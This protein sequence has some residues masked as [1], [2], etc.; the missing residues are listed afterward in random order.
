MYII[1]KLELMQQSSNIE[2]I[3]YTLSG[4]L[5]SNLDCIDKKNLKE[6]SIETQISQASILRFCQKFGYKGVTHFI[7]DLYLETGELKNKLQFFEYYDIQI[8]D[9]MISGFLK[10][11]EQAISGQI[12]ELCQRIRTSEKIMFYGHKN[13]MSCFQY[14]ISY[15][16]FNKKE[17]ITNMSLSKN[18]Q[19]EKFYSLT[20][21]DLLI[22]VEPYINWN[23]YRELTFIQNDTI[24][25]IYSTPAKIIYIGQNSQ[26]DVELCLNLPYTYY[27]YF[28]K[29][30][31]NKLDM[32]LTLKLKE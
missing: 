16:Y 9:T 32:I 13:Y 17:V 1:D 31:F 23:T 6:I 4:Y 19:I 3:E 29:N 26:N 18:N 28:Y 25:N 15:C 27:D 5:L 11:C 20:K 8:L 14:L 2:T 24:N 22:I 12:D 10:E 30:F 7:N 21:N